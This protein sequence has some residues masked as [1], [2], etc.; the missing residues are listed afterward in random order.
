MALD[1]P[2]RWL[3]LGAAL[4][5]L[6]FFGMLGSE[7]STAKSRS[8]AAQTQAQAW[9]PRQGPEL[10]LLSWRWYREYGYIHVEGEVQNISPEPMN[11]VM[12]V[13]L[14]RTEGEEFVRKPTP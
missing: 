6:V 5:A 2:T 13:A 9:A 11:N 7:R 12:V 4:G 8:A 10:R 1:N 3:S 14:L